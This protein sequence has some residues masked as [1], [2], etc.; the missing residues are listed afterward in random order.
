MTSIKKILFHCIGTL[1]FFCSTCGAKQIT[2]ISLHSII[3][4]ISKDV[5][6]NKV[7]VIEL[8]KPDTDPHTFEPSAL[9]L[10]SSLSADLILAS[11]LG[12]ESYLSKI[13]SNSNSNAKLL[14]LGEELNSWSHSQNQDPHWWQSIDSTI[15][16]TRIISKTLSSLSSNDSNYFQKQA[17]IK[18]NNLIELKKWVNNSLN[19]VQ[20]GNRALVTSHDSFSRFAHDFNFKIYPISGLSPESEPNAKDIA[21]LI[22]FI[23]T[24]HI[25]TIFVENRINPKITEGIIHD[26]GCKLGGTLYSDG[27]GT[28]ECQTYV[29]MYKHNVNEIVKGLK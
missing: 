25:K 11:G 2:I 20:L 17:E 26:T 10:R 18:I 24:A 28:K 13:V 3:T 8:I 15:L 12:L 19:Q 4:E 27:L 29:S 7:Q 16:A 23:R 22:D 6:G 1:A 9:D 14:L 5:G 21:S